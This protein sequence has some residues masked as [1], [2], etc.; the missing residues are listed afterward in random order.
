MLLHNEIVVP[1][2]T[3][4]IPED[5]GELGGDGKIPAISRIK[6]ITNVYHRNKKLSTFQQSMP[7]GVLRTKSGLIYF[8]VLFSWLDLPLEST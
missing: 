2:V 1:E 3:S 4:A 7:I 8:Y 5:E 6:S